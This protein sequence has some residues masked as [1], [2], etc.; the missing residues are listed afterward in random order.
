MT[1]DDGARVG[2]GEDDAGR[3]DRDVGPGTD[4]DADVGARE[5]RG[6]V[7]PV[8]DHRD[9]EP[10]AL[11]LDDGVLLVLGEDLGEHL[12]D[13]ELGRNWS[14]TC[15]GVAGDHDDAHA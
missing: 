15:S 12:V 7:H 2:R 9:P 10:A 6:V 14:A 4:R 8:A 5:R 13:A 1:L 3:F 11:E